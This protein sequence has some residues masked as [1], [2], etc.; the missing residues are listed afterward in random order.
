MCSNPFHTYLPIL[1]Q[2]LTDD[3]PTLLHGCFEQIPL[4]SETLKLTVFAIPYLTVFNNNMVPLT[5]YILSQ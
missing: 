5:A 2:P 3:G 4:S 1:H